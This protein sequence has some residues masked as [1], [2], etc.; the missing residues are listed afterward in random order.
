MLTYRAP[1]SWVALLLPLTLIPRSRWESDN[2]TLFSR[3]FITCM[4]ATQFLE[5]Y[6]VAGSQGGVAAIPMILG[7]FVCIA[8]AIVGLQT[9]AAK[10]F[11]N[12]ER[13]RLD[14][15][16]G[17]AML[18]LFAGFRVADVVYGPVRHA[19]DSDRYPMAPYLDPLKA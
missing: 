1:I 6:P 14:A 19:I 3:L 10:S 8:D 7:A 2:P 18:L 9:A 12:I 5:A 16:I 15:I 11:Q 4:A 17:G 13:L